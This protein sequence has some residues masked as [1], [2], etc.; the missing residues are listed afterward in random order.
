MEA[1]ERQI[2]ASRRRIFISYGRD[3][4]SFFPERVA[5]DLKKE[6]H[7]VY[8][9]QDMGK[10]EPFDDWIQARLAQSDV[11]LYF[12]SRHSTRRPDSVCLDEIAYARSVNLPVVPVL[13]EDATPPFLVSRINWLDARDAIDAVN[14][15]VIEARYQGKL[16][17]ILASLQN[18]I[19]DDDVSGTAIDLKKKLSPQDPSSELAKTLAPGGFFA[20]RPDFEKAYAAWMDDPMSHLMWLVAAPGSGKSYLSSHLANEDPRVVGIHFCLRRDEKSLDPL[21]ILKDLAYS[22]SVR[23]PSYGLALEE[24]IDFSSLDKNDISKNFYD[25]FVRSTKGLSP[26]SSLVFVIDGLDECRDADI[27]DIGLA[28]FENLSSLPRW[29]KILVTSRNGAAVDYGMSFTKRYDLLSK[30]SDMEGYVHLLSKQLKVAVT[31][32]QLKE[33]VALAQGNF[34]LVKTFFELSAGRSLDVDTF[35]GGMNAV[36]AQSFRTSFGKDGF[37]GEAKRFLSLLLAL[38][39]P[40]PIPRL[41]KILGLGKDDLYALVKKFKTLIVLDDDRPFLYHK[42]LGD[43]LSEPSNRF[44]V[45]KEAGNRLIADYLSKDL[46]AFLF[47]PYFRRYGIEHLFDEGDY[48]GIYRLLKAPFP[49]HEGLVDSLSLFLSRTAEDPSRFGDIFSFLLNGFNALGDAFPLREIVRSFV[50]YGVYDAMKDG[51]GYLMATNPGHEWVLPYASLVQSRMEVRIED[52]Y[53]TPEDPFLQAPGEVKAD[54]Y[55][56]RAEASRELGKYE[57]ALSLYEKSRSLSKGQDQFAYYMSS[58]KIS[59]L[60]FVFGRYEEAL[61]IASS[62]RLERGNEE[63]NFARERVLGHIY[64]AMK[65]D[66]EARVHYEEAL[67]IARDMSKMYAIVESLNSLAT[68]VPP[69]EAETLLRR[70]VEQAEGHGYKL[71]LGKAY[72]E[73]GNLAYKAKKPGE[74][75]GYAKLSLKAQSEVGYL[76]GICNARYLLALCEIHGGKPS[77]AREAMRKNVL[78]LNHSGSSGKRVLG[79]LRLYLEAKTMEGDYSPIEPELLSAIQEKRGSDDSLLKAIDEL[80]EGLAALAAYASSPKEDFRI[81][82]HNE[83]HEINVNE[84]RYVIRIPVADFDAVDIRLYDENEV[85]L[86]LEEIAFPIPHPRYLGTFYL[87]GR[88]ASVHS[89]LPGE[90]LR[91]LL[92]NDEALPSKYL[93]GFLSILKELHARKEIPLPKRG[94]YEDCPSFYRYDRSFIVALVGKWFGRYQAFYEKLGYPSDLGLLFPDE[95]GKVGERPFAMCHC[96][97]HRGNVLVDDKGALSLI[98]WEL[99]QLSDPLYDLA[100][101]LHK[102]FYEEAQEKELLDAYFR[103]FPELDPVSSKA[104]IKA[105]RDMEEVKS[106]TIDVLRLLIELPLQKREEGVENAGR[107]LMKLKA[108]S[109][110]HPA[111]RLPFANA[112]ELYDFLLKEG[113]GID[114]RSPGG[115]L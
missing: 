60:H 107:Y 67:K 95:E 83:N 71:E 91:S 110:S 10:G 36:F 51:I 115:K 93:P 101:H 64:H 105:Y 18:G 74:A 69:T 40:L 114:P 75:E 15:L 58:I 53:N 42:S 19:Q 92:P 24:N 11:V 98:D 94:D 27:G 100:I 52:A 34:L 22:L 102:M 82:Y 57:E 8:F 73:L 38:K 62:L 106:A 76:G 88:P 44:Y 16:K 109:A 14:G 4:L 49:G 37:E 33:I 99:F 81:G 48:E 39:E 12:M 29:M 103:A 90:A 31:P 79:S 6:G 21:L 70:A 97:L 68:V 41:A 23:F 108:L 113:Q 89:Y 17:A 47:D 112:E 65:K 9:D 20:P 86:A 104:A 5:S 78:D 85:L 80:S 63:G 84:K 43:W 54:Y 77:A 25:F 1:T 46:S 50:E 30:E 55:Y 59:D 56:Y 61:K 35:R 87:E 45:S 66:K 7:E 32:D 3:Y 28:L 13:I 26:E 96:D 111:Y 2:A 72:L